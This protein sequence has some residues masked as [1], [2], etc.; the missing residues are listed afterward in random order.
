MSPRHL[1]PALPHPP[2]TT[3]HLPPLFST[4]FRLYTDKYLC[5][6]THTRIVPEFSIMILCF[7]RHSSFVPS[8]LENSFSL[9][10]QSQTSCLWRGTPICGLLVPLGTFSAS[11]HANPLTCGP[12]VAAATEG[13]VGTFSA[14]PR[15]VSRRTEAS[16]VRGPSAQSDL[17][18]A[19]Y[20]VFPAEREPLPSSN[21][22]F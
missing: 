7:H 14:A 19:V 17:Q 20:I 22:L 10:L 3:Y 11:S 1:K 8:I 13:R 15:S 4:T 5:L 6:Q 18:N 16:G 2:P 9:P 21:V 12:S